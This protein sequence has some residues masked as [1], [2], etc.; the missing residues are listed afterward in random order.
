MTKAKD[1]SSLLYYELTRTIL[2][3]SFQVHSELGYGFAEVVYRN[4]VA[5][6]LRKLGLSV[7][8]EV[9]YEVHFHGEL[10]GLYRADLIVE[11]KVIVEVKTG[12]KIHPVHE[13]IVRN[14]LRAPD[15]A[16]GLL[17]NFGPR[18]EFRR[19]IWTPRGAIATAR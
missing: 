10:V 4:S 8:R 6:L 16:I 17:F 11:S 14:Y 9:E 15:R 7:Q 12:L 19:F 18:A 5:V 13:S 1:E 3:A 2:G